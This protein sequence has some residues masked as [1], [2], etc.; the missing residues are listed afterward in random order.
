MKV[1]LI[2]F[3]HLK[4]PYPVFPLGL[5]YVAGGLAPHTVRILDL[6]PT[7]RGAEAEPIANAVRELGPDAVGITIR[8]IDNTDNA[9][10][11]GF[12]DDMRAVVDAVRATTA[13]PIILGGAGF[14]LFPAE[15][16]EDLGA[17][18]GIVG[19]GERFKPLLEALQASGMA[20]GL[21]GSALEG[22]A[23]RGR[24]A[25]PP[26]PWRGAIQRSS[27]ELNPLLP[28]YL[29]HGGMLS[30]QTQRGCPFRCIY[31]TYPSIEGRVLRPIDLAQVGQTARRLQDAGAKYLFVTDSSFNASPEHSLA[32]AEAFRAAGVS[33]PWG[34]FFTPVAPLDGFYAQLAKAGCTHVEFGTDVLCDAMLERDQKPFRLEHVRAAHAQAQAAGL[35]VSHFLLLGGPGESAETVDQTLANAE[36]LPETAF[37]FFCGMR[38]YP[39]TDLYRRAVAEGQ[40][41][42]GQN[43]LEPVFYRPE[44][45]DLQEI[46]ARVEK[47]ARG[48]LNWV[49]GGGS[50]RA[51]DLM[52]RMYERGRSGP[53]WERLI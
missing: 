11:R 42:P 7:A 46:V 14:T 12:L 15:L 39:N 43:L 33:V 2:N 41:T 28:W 21:D 22:V 9:H 4:V 3:N 35:F 1:L 27:P 34:A 6:C 18:Y 29:E 37:F 24:P 38:I 44:T 45:I 48:R 25:P 23:V 36:L 13:A 30:L 19:E 49:V 20:R 50:E 40:I 51:A 52:W 47:H 26:V 32:V 10:L 31:C 17:D 5:D 8:N 53:L 16:L